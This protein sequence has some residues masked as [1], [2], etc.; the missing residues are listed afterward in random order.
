VK[1]LIV[2]PI[3]PDGLALLRAAGITP[4][5]ASA[6]DM[7]TVAAEIGGCVA[8]ITRNAGLNRAAM[9]AA[10]GLRV[11]GNHGTGLDPVDMATADEIGLPVV[12]TPEA[13]VQ[14]VAE[15]VLAQILALSRRLH[16]CDAEVRAGRFDYRYRGDFAEVAGK[17][18]LVVGFGRIGQRVAAMARAGFGMRVLVHAPSHPPAGIAAAGCEGAPDLDAALPQAD[19]VTLHLPLTPATRGL[20]GAGRLAAMKRG[21]TLVNTARGALVDAA[22]LAA[23]VAG[24]HLR[25]AA[26]DVFDPEPLPAGHPLTQVPGIL[27]TPH[28]GGSTVEALRRTGLAVAAQVVAVLRGE[29]PEHLANPAVWDRRRRPTHPAAGRDGP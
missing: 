28:V 19:H 3:H 17:T 8:A 24:G 27:L 5:P 18:L 22:A 15:L 26:L 25:G 11:L 4:V 12:F 21:A 7:A 2:Q 20:F 13:N 23:A 29:R 16:A 1:C 10:P 14:S 9:L 6:P